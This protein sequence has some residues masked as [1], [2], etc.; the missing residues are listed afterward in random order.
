MMYRW[1]VAAALA[2]VLPVAPAAADEPSPPSLAAP[3][4]VMALQKGG[5]AEVSWSPV[6]GATTY[7]ASAS[8]GQTCTTTATTCLFSGLPS[9]AAYTFTVTAGDGSVTSAP[10]APSRA[11]FLRARLDRPRF[12]SDRVLVGR[13]LKG[14]PI[15]AQRQGDPLSATVLLS[16]GQMHGSEP[17]GLRVTDRVRALTVPDDAP[18]QLWTIR[19]MNPDGAA[20]GNRY[21]ARGVDLN[22]NFPGT[23]ARQ[24]R[25]GVKP[26]SEPETRAMMRFLKR[27]QPTGVLS[28]HQPWDTTLSVCDTRSA[29]WVRLAA[30]LTGVRAPGTPSRCGNWLPGTMNRWTSRHTGAW[31]VTVELPASFKVGAFIP[32]S[33][34]AVVAIAQTMA[35]A[36]SGAAVGQTLAR[37][38]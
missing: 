1:T 17:A 36:D 27:L 30:Q 15:W 37:R 11:V 28:F 38:R 22:R 14:R 2:L 24:M 20:R 16:V 23:W 4:S 34:Q 3:G 35:A 33:A 5:D 25:T 29:A 21:N 10:S 18:Y 26:A 32:R 13:S 7:T 12:G 6:A 19:T 8:S 31:F 9:R